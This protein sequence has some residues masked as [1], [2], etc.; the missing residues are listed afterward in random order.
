[1]GM[2]LFAEF[3]GSQG[4]FGPEAAKAWEQEQR[5]LGERGELY[6]SVTQ[7]CFSARRPD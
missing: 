7:F 5:E 2:P 4:E 3:I 1:M 6:G